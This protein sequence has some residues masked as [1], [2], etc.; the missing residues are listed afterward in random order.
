MALGLLVF[1]QHHVEANQQVLGVLDVSV[2]QDQLHCRG[3]LGFRD[4]LEGD[5]G[6]E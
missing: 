2:L 6:V 3:G 5:A 1:V 4:A